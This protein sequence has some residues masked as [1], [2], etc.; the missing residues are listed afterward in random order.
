MPEL[1]LNYGS[2]DIIVDLK[3]ENL[4]LIENSNFDILND[5][6]LDQEI[7]SIQI[8]DNSTIVPLD[9]SNST[10]QIVS[11]LIALAEARGIKIS[12]E[13]ILK[14]R[15]QLANKLQSQSICTIEKNDEHFQNLIREKNTLFVSKTHIDPLFGYSGTPVTLIREIEQDKMNEAFQARIDDLPHPATIGPPIEVANKISEGMNAKSIEIVSNNSGINNIYYGEILE[16]FQ[17]AIKKLENLTI[18]NEQELKS[19]IVGTNTDTNSSSTLSGSLNLLWNSVNALKRN[20]IVVMV[21]ENHKG[22]GAKAIEKFAYGEI[23]LEDY[24]NSTYLEGLEH[25]MFINQLREK[26]NIAILSSLPKYYL[27]EIFGLKVFS[28]IQEAAERILEMN[29]K[30]HKISIIQD[31]NIALFKKR[32]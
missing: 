5:E 9:A 13:S 2:T 8:E 10:V 29:G 19:L 30:S 3:V 1:W 31:P 7:E 14:T 17:N 27:K 32:D 28:N 26:Y 12:I 22:F 20:A 15:K 6:I 24:K 25:I 21:S 18:E 11:R 4:S 23:K 16:S